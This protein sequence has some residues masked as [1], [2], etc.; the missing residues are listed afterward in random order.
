MLPLLFANLLLREPDCVAVGHYRE[1]FRLEV[2]AADAAQ[3]GFAAF[4]RSVANHSMQATAGALDS[5]FGFC[6][7]H[8]FWLLKVAGVTRRA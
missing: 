6:F 8:I 7:G 5:S 3:L 2:V 4:G 1:V